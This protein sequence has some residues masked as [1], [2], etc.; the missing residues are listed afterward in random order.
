MTVVV[1]ARRLHHPVVT[2]DVDDMHCLD[3]SLELIP[4]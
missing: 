3:P 4:I 2:E 1:L